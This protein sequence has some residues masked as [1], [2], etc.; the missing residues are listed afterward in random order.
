MLLKWF[1]PQANDNQFRRNRKFEK[2]RQNSFLHSNFVCIFHLETYFYHLHK[3][4]G[5]KGQMKYKNETNII[6]DDILITAKG[7]PQAIYFYLLFFF[8]ST[9]PFVAHKK[10]QSKK[11]LHMQIIFNLQRIFF[12]L[13]H[14]FRFLLFNIAVRF[15]PSIERHAHKHTESM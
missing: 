12:C 15:G 11:K 4:T 10:I 5:W 1:I 6:I 7:L 13:P 2:N 8:V 9:L 3:L 14:C